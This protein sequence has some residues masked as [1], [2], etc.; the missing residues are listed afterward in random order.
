MHRQIRWA[1]KF[2]GF[3]FKIVYSPGT[4]RGKPDALSRRP[5]YR[6]EE[7]ATHREQEILQPNHFGKFQIAVVWGSNSEQLQQGLPQMEK[8]TRIRVQR[9][10]KDA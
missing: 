2:C 5:E 1:Q 3:N 6:P 4:K 9:L 10:S 7:G 8:E